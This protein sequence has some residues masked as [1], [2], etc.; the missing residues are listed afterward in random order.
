MKEKRRVCFA[1]RVRRRLPFRHLIQAIRNALR[2]TR[3]FNLR[4]R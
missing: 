2:R 3:R 1:R 4:L